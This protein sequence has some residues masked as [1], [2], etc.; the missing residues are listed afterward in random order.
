MSRGDEF[1]VEL[2]CRLSHL[3]VSEV[4]KILSFYSESIQ[5]KVEDGWTEEQ[6]VKS[7][8]NMN[9]IVS[10]IEAD[11]PFGAFV[12]DKVVS[13]SSNQSSTVKVLLIVIAILTLPIWVPI[14]AVIF[15]VVVMIYAV[16]WII[17]I[18][19][20]ALYFSLY[21]MAI[22]GVIFGF[23]RIFTVSFSTGLGYLGFGLICTG[24]VIMLLKPLGKAGSLW[25]KANIWPFKK[26]K[27]WIVRR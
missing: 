27:Q 6:A 18:T 24:L 11:I 3:P 26:L 2:K 7:F 14:V 5:D 17:P 10:N 22:S 9:E 12:K 13:K 20:G 1:L 21:L 19:I 16:L 8:G 23:L 4:G 15:A 25:I